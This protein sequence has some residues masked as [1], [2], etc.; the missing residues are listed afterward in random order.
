MIGQSQAFRLIQAL[1]DKMAAFDA[2]VLIEGE[3]GT[4]KELAARAIHYRGARRN[5]PFVPVNCGA[6]LDQ[7]IENEL[8]GHRRGAFT[9]ARDNQPGLV[10]LARGGTLFLDEIDT[11]TPKGQV[12]LLRFLQDQQFRPLGGQ[13][14]QQ[15]DVR[16][17][18]AS[19]RNLERQVEAGE[20]RLDLLYRLKLLYLTLPPLKERYGDIPLLAEHFIRVGSARFHK[21]A[22]PLATATLAWFQHYQWPGNIRELEN[23]I[24]REFL[25]ADGAQISIPAPSTGLSAG[26]TGEG[27]QLNL[28]L[29]K[30]QAI[31]EFESRFLSRLIEQANGNISAAARICGTERRYLG[32]LLKKYHIPKFPVREA[33][34][35]GQASPD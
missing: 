10:E 31:K 9:D 25:L 15:A 34:P 14:E 2:P 7:L 19:N 32:R 29:A 5:G 23:L 17:I 3:T 4:G 30:S 1:I 21:E 26:P 20:F 12:T 33:G 27:A 8:F 22:I 16:V 24:L 13:R 35:A 6:L 11:L 28:R 18:A